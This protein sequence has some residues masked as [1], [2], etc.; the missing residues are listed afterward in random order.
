MILAI[1]MGLVSW[2]ICAIIMAFLSN[3]LLTVVDTVFMCFLFDKENNQV[4]KPELHE[5]MM[6]VLDRNGNKVQ[7]PAGAPAQAQIQQVQP[8]MSVAPVA[9]VNAPPPPAYTPQPRFDPNT[10][11]PIQPVAAVPQQ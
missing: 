1:I 9:S 4:S 7:V 11:Q 3:I 10:G 5:I 8:A 6:V 2:I